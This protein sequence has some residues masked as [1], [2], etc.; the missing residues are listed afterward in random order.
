MPSLPSDKLLAHL[1]AGISFSNSEDPTAVDDYCA[2]TDI[3]A[4]MRSA[5][6]E[7]RLHQLGLRKELAEGTKSKISKKL[8]KN[9]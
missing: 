6:N 1:K 8:I 4:E 3:K 2:D 7:I 5:R 9:K